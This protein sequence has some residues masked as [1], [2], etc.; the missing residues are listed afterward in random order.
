MMK[1]I[2]S[3]MIGCLVVFTFALAQ[4]SQDAEVGAFAKNLRNA[5]YEEC[6]E[7]VSERFPNAGERAQTFCKR[8]ATV[9]SNVQERLAAASVSVE[10]W[11]EKRLDAAGANDF[12]AGLAPEKARIFMQLSRAEQKRILE[13]K[14]EGLLDNYRLISAKKDELFKKRL[15]AKNRMIE[16]EQK[17][18]KA[19]GRFLELVQ[20]HNRKRMAWLEAKDAL[21][22]ACKDP[23]SQECR[24]AEAEAIEK[25]REFLSNSIERAAEHLNQILARVQASEG[26][27]EEEAQDIEDD[28]TQALD[29]LDSLKEELESASSK[30]E[31]KDIARQ[32]DAM[33]ARFEFRVAAH[34][35]HSFNARVRV[36]I[37]QTERM[38]GQFDCAI[39]LI[40]EEGI[41][42][43]ELEDLVDAFSIQVAE[44]KASY[45]KA[46]DVYHE[47]MDMDWENER[48]EIRKKAKEMQDHVKDAHAD[49]REAHK[50]LTDIYRAIR[51]TGVNVSECR[52]LSDEVVAV[53]EI[54][55]EPEDES[56]EEDEEE[57]EDES[58]EEDEYSNQ[59]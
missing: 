7:K 57:S 10:K 4:G 52:D 25:A 23:E 24:D 1:K 12:V 45:E 27:T 13:Q 38:E 47:I 46:K 17:Y 22:E 40:E 14:K 41:E 49:L 9:R 31:I 53:E 33:W 54:E 5:T 18:Q 37:K 26:L 43:G 56:E 35:A 21:K 6:L 50:T 15:I 29:K 58:E 3:V 44:A 28:I 42:T 11:Q 30:E 2:M 8:Y 32:L 19:R 59:E 36:I 48:D 39:A 34:A 20:A 16:L 51:A 55:D